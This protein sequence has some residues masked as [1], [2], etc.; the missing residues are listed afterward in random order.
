MLMTKRKL[1]TV[2]EI[3]VEAFMAQNVQRRSDLWKAM[4][5]SHER[6]RIE[7][8]KPLNDAA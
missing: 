6:L 4:H 8:T 5:G 7:R 2:A 3:L 1:A